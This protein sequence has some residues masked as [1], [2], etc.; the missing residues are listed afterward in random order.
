M[1]RF[2]SAKTVLVLAL[3]AV[4]IAPLDAFG[5][6]WDWQKQVDR[7]RQ[8]GQDLSWQVPHIV[9]A[10]MAPEITDLYAVGVSVP[11]NARSA[12]FRLRVA[13]TEDAAIVN[14]MS[15]LGS[16]RDGF[17]IRRSWR[18]ITDTVVGYISD[19]RPIYAV[20]REPVVEEDCYD[21]GDRF[22]EFEVPGN[23][24]SV[25]V[26]VRTRFGSFYSK[27]SAESNSGTLAGSP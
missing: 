7:N 6:S 13:W 27:T 20:L 1:M 22:K 9:A 24:S 8:Q 12:P 10:K 16:P 14:R 18:V 19:G 4:W 3:A 21:S 5:Q 11:T 25:S 26:T 2:G 17:C 23:T 15:E